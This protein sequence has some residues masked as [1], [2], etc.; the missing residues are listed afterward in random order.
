MDETRGPPEVCREQKVLAPECLVDPRAQDQSPIH[1]TLSHA[2]QH[3]QLPLPNGRGWLVLRGG[4]SCRPWSV[5]E[6]FGVEGSGGSGQ[7]EEGCGRCGLSRWDGVRWSVKRQACQEWDSN[8]RLQGR[9]RP[10]R[11][12][13][14]RSAI[15]TAGLGRRPLASQAPGAQARTSRPDGTASRGR[16][17]SGR[18]WPRLGA[19]AAGLAR[20]PLPCQSTDDGTLLG[21]RVPP[22]AGPDPRPAAPRLSPQHAGWPGCVTPASRRDPASVARNH[23]HSA[24]VA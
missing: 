1:S 8:P 16:H 2:R 24:P 15:L 10:E 17:G 19:R 5:S 6:G 20:R 4:L 14:D 23:S 13:L 21:A 7:I 18:V 9:L 12:A 3:D 22:G 11:S